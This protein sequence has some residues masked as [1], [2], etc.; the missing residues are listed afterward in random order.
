MAD[1]YRKFHILPVQNFEHF[2]NSIT[3]LQEPKRPISD[4]A[5]EPPAGRSTAARARRGALLGHLR[6][7]QPALYGDQCVTV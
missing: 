5:A 2:G 3:I 7:H 4:A 1:G 6:H